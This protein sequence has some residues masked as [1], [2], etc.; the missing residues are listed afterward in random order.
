MIMPMWIVSVAAYDE[1]QV[2]KRLEIQN[3]SLFGNSPEADKTSPVLSKSI[4]DTK[5]RQTDQAKRRIAETLAKSKS[6]HLN[7]FSNSPGT[8]KKKTGIELGIVRKV[9]ETG[10]KEIL[11]SECKIETSGNSVVEIVTEKD[12]HINNHVDDNVP[13]CLSVGDSSGLSSLMGCYS[14]SEE[15]D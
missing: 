9:E 4:A 3:R 7:T 13:T 5:Q 15:S 2:E 8:S 14:S 11:E 1:K 6:K 12:C 10:K